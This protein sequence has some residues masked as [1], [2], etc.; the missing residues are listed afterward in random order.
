MCDYGVVEAAPTYSRGFSLVQG[1]R[2]STQNLN[3]CICKHAR[4]KPR[5]AEMLRLLYPG[6]C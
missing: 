1:T 4:T 2:R 5:E 6:T 3:A